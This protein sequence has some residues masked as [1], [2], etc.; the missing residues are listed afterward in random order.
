MQKLLKKGHIWPFF[1]FL[2]LGI[3]FI[4]V[5]PSTVQFGDTSEFAANGHLHR[6]SHPPG[7]PLFTYLIWL[8]THL[9]PFGS[10]F[11]RASVLQILLSLGSL[12]LFRN[13][14]KISAPLVLILLLS[15][16]FGRLFWRYSLL[17]DVFMLNLFLVAFYSWLYFQEKSDKNLYLSS[18]VYGLCLSHHQ[19]TVFLF[20]LFLAQAWSIKKWRTAF[21]ALLIAGL[22]MLAS[23]MLLF[24]LDDSSL[25]SWGRVNNLS[26]FF[27]HVLRKD[28]GTFTLSNSWSNNS[29][30]AENIKIFLEILLQDHFTYL[31]LICLALA[32]AITRKIQLSIKEWLYFFISIISFIAF[33]TLSNVFPK[34]AA[35]LLIERF[36]LLPLGMLGIWALRIIPK[37]MTPGLVSLLLTSGLINISTNLYQ[38]SGENNFRKDQFLHDHYSYILNNLPKDALYLVSGDTHVFSF[39]YLQEI[40]KLRPDVTIVVPPMYTYAWYREKLQTKYPNKDFSRFEIYSQRLEEN[41]DNLIVGPNIQKYRIFL[42]PYIINLVNFKRYHVVHMGILAEIKMGQLSSMYDC[43]YN[44]PLPLLHDLKTYQANLEVY[45]WYGS[46][47]FFAGIHHLKEGNFELA[48]FM[49]KRAVEKVPY[50]IMYQTALCEALTKG[51]NISEVSTCTRAI[52]DKSLNYAYSLF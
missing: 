13:T 42:D 1:I 40:L 28:Y 6:V 27:H 3:Y 17:P 10:I 41:I 34:G 43:K 45:Q 21:F 19:T 18:L 32:S 22:T 29:Y 24:F 20:P 12:I 37:M 39:Y 16:A 52:K 35:G 14:S 7:Y 2:G 26:D 49:L 8:A 15:L 33:F 44:R 38:Y 46:C 48:I 30:L 25:G 11:F 9:I 5:A 36:Y 31:L 51:E 50:S 47:D 23:Y 4:S